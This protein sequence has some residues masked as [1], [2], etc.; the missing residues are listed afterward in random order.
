MNIKDILDKYQISQELISIIIPIEKAYNENLISN[1]HL[2]ENE[3][4]S[5]YV[6]SYDA[7]FPISLT[8]DYI[9]K[10]EFNL[11]VSLKELLQNA[12]DEQEF[13]SG[14]PEIK[15][16]KDKLGIWIKDSGRGININ[17][18]RIGG[19]DKECWMRGYYGEG[20]KLASSYFIL[21]NIP[22]YFFTKNLVFKFIA[23][24]KNSNN[25]SIFVMMGRTNL[26]INGTHILLYGY[27]EDIKNIKK[28]IRFLNEDLNEKILLEKRYSD[29]NCMKE[30]PSAIF[31][32]HDQL[33]IR[34]MYVGRT[35][36][37]TKRESLLSYD[38]WWVRLDVSRKIMTQSAPL[39]F[40]EV[41]KLLEKSETARIIFAKKLIESGMLRTK[42]IYSGEIIEFEPIFSIFEGHL[43]VYSFPKG[44]LDA[45]IN[46]LGFSDK[47]E[48]IKK[49]STDEEAL[50]ELNKGFIPIKIQ[51]ET[52]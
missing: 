11:M 8:K 4:L 50:N 22:V 29:N 42:N 35:S 19:G 6:I 13:V 37:V 24:P 47:K 31:D 18:F 2:K 26:N 51:Y 45:F 28:L 9:E 33:Y 1:E 25:P 5:D 21:N 36:D 46:A 20:L 30:M 43:F 15:I 34:N 40:K 7:L 44:M 32:Y 10:R 49:V 52:F 39:I 3:E 27:N 12:L 38:L 16:D 14:N 23:L 48:I 17:A 41:V